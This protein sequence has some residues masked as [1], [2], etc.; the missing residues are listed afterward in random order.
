MSR[1]ALFAATLA[2]LAA[3]G[4]H[5][6]DRPRYS[7]GDCNQDGC[8]GCT[9]DSK[10]S[11]WPLPYQPCQ[12]A[13]ECKETE[14]CTNVGCAARCAADDDC[15][16]GEVCSAAGH[17]EPGNVSTNPVENPGGSPGPAPG[18]IPCALDSQCFPGEACIGGQCTHS[19]SCGIPAN[20]CN[21]DKD[22]GTGR[23]CSLGTCH[24]GCVLGADACPIG[25]VCSS[26]YCIDMPPQVAQCLFDY[27]CGPASRCIN[28]VCHPLC[29]VNSQ[30][31]RGEFCD[32]GVCRA[33][34]RPAVSVQR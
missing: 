15:R 6:D 9:D 22:C 5:H 30:C 3:A 7:Y 16:L 4:C 11:C 23:V 21:A 18:V 12:G 13:A 33:D 32:S 27:Q 29:G 20:L 31:G 14:I 1:H 2:A 10:R 17:C 8:F 28:A 24:Q 25:Q 19:A 34:I 26:G